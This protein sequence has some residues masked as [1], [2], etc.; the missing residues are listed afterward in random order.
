MAARSEIY[1]ADWRR[2]RAARTADARAAGAGGRDV[3]HEELVQRAVHDPWDDDDLPVHRPVLGGAR[4]LPR[5]A[6]DRGARHGVSATERVVVLAL[7][8]R[9]TDDVPQL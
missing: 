1:R 7:P 6:D 4:E 8:L 9:W 2:G 5:A 3:H